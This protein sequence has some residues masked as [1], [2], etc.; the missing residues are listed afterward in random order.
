MFYFRYRRKVVVIFLRSLA[1]SIHIHI[2]IGLLVVLFFI[3]ITFL[4]G[5]PTFSEVVLHYNPLLCGGGA[6][7]KN[8]E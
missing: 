5:K 4:S 7:Y 8:S 2:C 3:I 6:L 1:K